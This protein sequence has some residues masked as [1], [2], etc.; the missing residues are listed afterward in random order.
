M[1]EKLYMVV[2]TGQG[3]TIV[4]LVN[5]DVWNWILSPY[6]PPNPRDSAYAEKVPDA[7]L[8]EAER[9]ECESFYA[10]YSDMDEDGYYNVS[11]GSCDN[12]RALGAPGIQFWSIKEAM[13]FVVTNDIEIVEEY[14]GYIY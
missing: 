6:N 12:D 4:T 11:I 1:A 5:E 7:V 3:D 9:H 13:E 14:N 8:A 2:L 10:E